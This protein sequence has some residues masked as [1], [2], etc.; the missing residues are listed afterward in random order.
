MLIGSTW[1][2]EKPDG[3][4]LREL[5]RYPDFRDERLREAAKR[6]L[7]NVEGG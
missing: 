1:G 7:R 6:A 3:A 2:P 5:K 4:A